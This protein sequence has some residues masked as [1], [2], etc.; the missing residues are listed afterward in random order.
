MTNDGINDL[1][2]GIPG[3]YYHGYDAAGG[4]AVLPGSFENGVTSSFNFVIHE[5]VVPDVI[6]L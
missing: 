3:D 1:V 5:W 2:I 6:G 4:V